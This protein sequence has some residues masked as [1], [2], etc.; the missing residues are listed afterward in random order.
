MS[1]GASHV[2]DR[3]VGEAERIGFVAHGLHVRVG[4][5][6]AEHRWT[7]DI[8]EDVHSV[9]K[10]VCV[11]AAAI[12]ADEG[13]VA[14]DVPVAT[15][16]PALARGDGVEEVTLRHLLTMTSGID[17]P[18]SET[19]MTDW[20]DL[21][22]EFLRRPSRG[23]VFQYSN[24][25]TYTAM[26]VLATRVGDVGAF[27]DERLFRP[28]GIDGPTWARCP[29]GRI[30]AGGG[31][32]LRTAEVARLGVLIRDRGSWEGRQLV[33][34]PWIDAMHEGA[35]V[36][37]TSPGYERYGLAGWGGPGRAWRLHGAHGQ[38]LVFL[39]DAV[40]T[41]TAEDHGR[42]DA[43]AAAVVDILESLSA[44]DAARSGEELR[45]EV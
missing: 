43:M 18:W 16:V 37:G 15:Y 8:R 1:A 20:P 10:G 2:R 17:L 25:S 9:A 31:L 35:V 33:A 39:D 36:A 30:E 11:L 32:M 4:A 34:A 38:L 6:V 28:L 14:M 29:N 3:I 24:A 22:A 21:A 44:G 26:T 42:A 23:R 40:V 19:L 13:A 45:S 5:D 7:P 12:A 27:L 41:I